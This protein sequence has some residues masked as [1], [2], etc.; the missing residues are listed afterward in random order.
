L[1]SQYTTS[2]LL[3]KVRSTVG[4]V[5]PISELIIEAYGRMVARI[6]ADH[7][8]R[9]RQYVERADVEQELWL[10]FVEHPRKTV[11]WSKLDPKEGDS[12][13]ARSLRN[14]ALEYCLRE[15]AV[16]TGYEYE[17]QFFYT[18]D[19]VKTLLPAALSG[20][21]KRVQ[22][23]SSE[24]K[25]QKSPAESGDWMAYAAD[26][27]KA[28]SRL[29]DEEQRL[30][31]MFYAKDSTGED[32]HVELGGDRPSARATQMA[33]N[34]ALNKIVKFLGGSKPF[35]DTDDAREPSED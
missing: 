15:K 20:D 18:K 32:L 33:A 12:L 35:K 4:D 29:S 26:I 11:E 3:L 17:D 22:V 31:E 27:K 5:V 21:A 1:L 14:A 2:L 23:L 30:V 10:W 7:A 28:F 13:F 24:I 16:Q 25:V 9:F 34:R 6:A 19:M 8:N